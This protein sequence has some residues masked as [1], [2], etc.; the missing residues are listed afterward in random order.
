[1]LFFIGQRLD[2]EILRDVIDSVAEFNQLVVLSDCRVFRVN[3][4]FR[5]IYGKL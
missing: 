1:M 3:D 2:A 5:A 4:S